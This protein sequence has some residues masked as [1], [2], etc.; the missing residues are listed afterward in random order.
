M[1]NEK[2]FDMLVS[3]VMTV[4]SV[5]IVLPFVV[6]ISTSFKTMNEIMRSSL[7]FIPHKLLFSNYFAAMRMGQ[8]PWW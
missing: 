5:L 2:R 6:M 7:T 4:L 3:I 8:W 1:I